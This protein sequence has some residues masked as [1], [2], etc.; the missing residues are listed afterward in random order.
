MRSQKH[1]VTNLKELNV[2]IE[3]RVIDAVSEMAKNSG[4][5]LDDLVVI[6]LKRFIASHSDYKGGKDAA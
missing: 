1:N 5:S 2:K 6:A 4:I 3:E